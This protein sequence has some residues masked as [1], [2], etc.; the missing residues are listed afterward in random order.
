MYIHCFCR[1]SPPMRIVNV[2]FAAEN[3]GRRDVF[4]N[5][6]HAAASAGLP[7][8]SS[9]KLYPVSDAL[10][11]SATSAATSCVA[12][13]AFSSA[14]FIPVPLAATSASTPTPSARKACVHVRA[15]V[16]SACGTRAP[17]DDTS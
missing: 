5:A 2:M 1:Q 17:V 4:R 16:R 10:T 13:D 14:A 6:V 15:S 9:C 3:A 11:A 8:S 12:S 7:G